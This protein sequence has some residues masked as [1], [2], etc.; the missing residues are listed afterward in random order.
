MYII[1]IYMVMLS[2]AKATVLFLLVACYILNDSY[3]SIR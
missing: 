2:V 1:Y 3:Q